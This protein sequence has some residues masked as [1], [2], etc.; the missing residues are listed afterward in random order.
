MERSS[1]LL[2]S[3][4]IYH[5][6][7]ENRSHRIRRAIDIGFRVR[8]IRQVENQSLSCPMEIERRLP[9]EPVS[10]M[11]VASAGG[12]GLVGDRESA[13]TALGMTN[14]PTKSVS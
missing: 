6:G 13:L 7:D 5:G 11:G 9:K 4:K 10:L 8:W 2:F 3:S 14:E 12:Y 1:V